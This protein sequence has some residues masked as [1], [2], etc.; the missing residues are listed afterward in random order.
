M[1]IYTFQNHD[2][3]IISLF[4]AKS[5]MKCELPHYHLEQI[6][7][8]PHSPFI[9]KSPSFSRN[10]FLFQTKKSSNTHPFVSEYLCIIEM[11][12]VKLCCQFMTYSE[13]EA[14][15]EKRD[16]KVVTRFRQVHFLKNCDGKLPNSS[17]CGGNSFFSQ[18]MAGL[19]QYR[20]TTS[21]KVLCI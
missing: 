15:G 17:G 11:M 3:F 21:C 18:C 9:L 5:C 12:N 6:L 14:S 1:S 19:E 13:D 8:R 4:D 16:N 10:S 2:F 20:Q 7:S